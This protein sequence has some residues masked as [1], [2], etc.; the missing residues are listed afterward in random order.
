M[1]WLLGLLDLMNSGDIVPKAVEKARPAVIWEHSHVLGSTATS[2]EIEI[3]YIS[4][5]MTTDD[6]CHRRI[7]RYSWLR[8][9]NIIQKR[10]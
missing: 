1:V 8:S 6:F 9:E 3:S 4:D 5:L 7:L 2:E 10:G